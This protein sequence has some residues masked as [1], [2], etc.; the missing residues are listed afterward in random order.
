[1]KTRQWK[2]GSHVLVLV[3]VSLCSIRHVA[4][5]PQWRVIPVELNDIEDPVVGDFA[6]GTDGIP[7][8]ITAAP[9]QMVAYW[10]EG[11]WHRLLADL[12]ATD[13]VRLHVAPT[14]RVYLS[15]RKWVVDASSIS[16]QKDGELYSLE[17]AQASHVTDFALGRYSYKGALFFDSKGRIWNWGNT[18]IAKF[19]AG[20]WD[21]VE[22][23]IGNTPQILE[24]AKG[25][26]YFFGETL[27]YY[28]DK[29]FTVNVEAPAL[30]WPREAIR[31]CLWRK[32]KALFLAYGHPGL[33][34]FDLNTHETRDV[35]GDQAPWARRTLYDMFTDTRGNLWVLAYMSDSK[36]CV[37]HKI[38]MAS[39]SVM[40]QPKI[41]AVDSD[42]RI[43]N[44]PTPVLCANDGTVCIGTER[45]GV[46]LCRDDQ[47]SH[48]SWPQGLSIN[49]TRWIYEHPDRTVWFASE[50]MGVAVYDPQGDSEPMPAS[51]FQRSWE[52]YPLAA[53]STLRD[54]QG[55]IWCCL[56]DKP[57]KVSCWDGRNWQHFGLGSNELLVN[58]LWC[59]DLGRIHICGRLSSRRGARA[60]ACRLVGDSIDEFSNT[61]EMLVNSVE[62]GSRRFT[63]SISFGDFPPLVTDDGEIWYNRTSSTYF[64]RYVAGKWQE[65]ATTWPGRWPIKHQGSQ[66]LVRLSGRFMHWDRGQFADFADESTRRQEYLLGESG[67]Q[68]FDR[69]LRQT[70]PT[71]FFPVR[72]VDGVLGV[73]KTLSDFDSGRI[74]ST[75]LA[76]SDNVG[77][78]WL[79]EGGFWLHPDSQC[80]LKRYFDGLM[81]TVDL[82]TTPVAA[83]LNASSCDA[84][85]DAGGDLWIRRDKTLFHVRRPVLQTHVTSPQA[86]AT[87]GP[88]SRIEF[89]GS[90]DR[91]VDQPLRYAWRVDAGPW[92][93]PTEQT[94]ADMEFMTSGLHRFEVLSVGP[95]A[96]IDTT[97][98]EVIVNVRLPETKVQI[99]SSPQNIVT[100]FDVAIVFETIGPLVDQDVVFQWR[101]DGGPWRQTGETT[102]WLPP[103]AD[104]EHRFEV[105]SVTDGKYVQDPSAMVRFEVQ[106]DY[107]QAV[108]SA[109]EDLGAA[110][111]DQRE[112]A[113]RRLI[114]LGESTVPY[115]EEA[116][117]TADEDTQWWIQAVTE[118]IRDQ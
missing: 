114:F 88:T 47:I 95:Q 67:L 74:P 4:A 23:N 115:L 69:A 80:M 27:C 98:A 81:L 16:P 54:P 11:R 107:E 108:R 55:R 76:S 12:G 89:I 104:G 58:V 66:V 6:L 29:K 53:R 111:Y 101:I 87:V 56:E 91:P 60:F 34:A 21:R 14:G 63:G 100:N 71:E 117:K 93:E 36:R 113:A 5:G 96:S 44:I 79:A 77:R 64:T 10:R 86:M 65:I 13:R 7:W 33:I 32:D 19:E 82:A 42:D 17:G 116:L 41:E 78:I 62:T 85:E 109:I 39:G 84:L 106:I 59:D 51:S 72:V 70:H 46:Y 75:A 49:T 105:R 8:I 97:A 112:V 52:Q 61:Q 99:V 48:I 73:F 45:D 15:E 30:P 38:S 31:S 1:M 50:R 37:Y 57:G 103:L 92:S 83:D 110:D 102:V 118:R 9:R 2:I 94:Y 24:D 20:Q 68:P 26:V 22:A 18:F 25:N 35:L 3:A 90:A 43:E 40:G 28:R